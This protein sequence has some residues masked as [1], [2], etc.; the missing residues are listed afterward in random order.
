[1]IITNK[2]NKLAYWAALVVAR[3]FNPCPRRLKVMRGN[4]Y[5]L[6][7]RARRQSHKF[8]AKELARRLAN[9]EETRKCHKIFSSGSV[10]MHGSS[11]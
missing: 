3:V 10:D 8:Q 1:M 7:I 11:G 5:V 6:D 2:N 4:K 9:R